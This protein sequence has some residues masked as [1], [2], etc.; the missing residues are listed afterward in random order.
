MLRQILSDQIAQTGTQ[1][2]FTQAAGGT[3]GFEGRT[4]PE[5]GRP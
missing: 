3:K 2:F 1:Q 5:L 4:Q